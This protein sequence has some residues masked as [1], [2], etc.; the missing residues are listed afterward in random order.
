MKI[1]T[2]AKSKKKLVTIALVATFIVACGAYVAIAAT[3]DLWPF[4]NSDKSQTDNQEE[5]D[6]ES[7]VTDGDIDSVHGNN[8]S[9]G[10][11]NEEDSPE[12]HIPPKYDTPANTPEPASLTGVI[13]HAS[14]RNDNLVI[15]TTIN[16]FLSSG[17]CSLTLTRSSDSKTV[18]KRTSI[19]AGPSTSS[20]DGFDIPTTELGSGNWDIVINL[21]SGDRQGRLT[22]SIS[23]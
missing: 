9:S 5:A 17:D 11:G 10:Q 23:I 3:N 13:S 2:T 7:V 14:V 1:N 21:K 20:C 15:R 4:A 12:N 19:A 16:Q 22:Q 18:T 8:N 6:T